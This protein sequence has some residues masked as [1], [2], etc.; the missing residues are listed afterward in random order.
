MKKFLLIYLSILLALSGFAQNFFGS[1]TGTQ[2]EPPSV[3]IS[4][5]EIISPDAWCGFRAIGNVTSEGDY[6]VSERGICWSESI[7]PTIDDY[8]YSNSSGGGTFSIDYFGLDGSKTFY[9]RAYAVFS[10]GVVY[11]P[12]EQSLSTNPEAVVEYS[13]SNITSTSI[14]IT[15][16][17]TANGNTITQRYVWYGT[18]GIYENYH[19]I[20]PGNNDTTIVLD[21]LQPDTKYYYACYIKA[22]NCIDW[23][24]VRSFT[25]LPPSIPIVQTALMPTDV[26]ETTAQI[27]GVVTDDGGTSVTQIGACCNT[28]GNPTIS[29]NQSFAF[30][31]NE[32]GWVTELSGLSP[33][34]HYFVRSFATNSVGTGYGNQ[35]EIT[36]LSIS[37]PTI[38]TASVSNISTTTATCGGNVTDEGG[39]SIIERGIC[40]NTTGNPN[41]IDDNSMSTSGTIGSFSVNLTDLPS[42]TII[43]VKAYAISQY[44]AGDSTIT[45]TGY[46]NE[47]NFTTQ[48][49]GIGPT[50]TAV[51]G[52]DYRL[53]GAIPPL[54]TSISKLYDLGDVFYNYVGDAYKYLVIENVNLDYDG[55]GNSIVAIKDN[56]SI[57]S[58]FPYYIDI[59]GLA[60]YEYIG[61]SIEYYDAT[62]QLMCGGESQQVAFTWH[63]EDVNS[64]SGIT[65]DYLGMY[66]FAT[67]IDISITNITSTTAKASV[68]AYGTSLNSVEVYY[69]TLPFTFNL[70]GIPFFSKMI[71]TCGT[72]SVD[73]SS[74]SPNTQY[75]YRMV[76]R[77]NE[78]SAWKSLQYT[79]T[80]AP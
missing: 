34:T 26:G 17:I 51:N 43:Y 52:I 42:S 65:H 68:T 80:T 64:L 18:S 41:M 1:H 24:G 12:A 15:F 23:Y 63:V 5:V 33:G 44:N 25:T 19:P 69:S 29:D 38:S 78:F 35:I 61:L 77:N 45:Q 57:I 67:G 16:D 14:N 28:T 53:N 3:L 37:P 71:S 32:S 60:E 8:K 2:L 70:S 36:T 56:G 50:Y 66:N 11:S 47:V 54:A 9:F 21:N 39:A 79:F 62:S 59:E 27:G 22:G 49:L 73:M 76:V 55:D 6:T 20:S 40:W 58:S 4:S 13:S 7:N 30:V 31:G 74:L 10:D 46:G 72:Y 75:Y 48:T